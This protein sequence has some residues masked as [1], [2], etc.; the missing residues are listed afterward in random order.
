MR[1]PLSRAI[2]LNFLGVRYMKKKAVS[3]LGGV[4]AFVAG[5]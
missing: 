4:V 3:M 1:E 2:Q 5:C